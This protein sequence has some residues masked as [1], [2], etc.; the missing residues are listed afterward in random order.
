MKRI[1][2]RCAILLP[3]LALFYFSL[4]TIYKQL[5][6]GAVP[7]ADAPIP[8]TKIPPQSEPAPE[9]SAGVHPQRYDGRCRAR[10]YTPAPKAKLEIYKWVDAN[11]RTHFGDS[12]Q[13]KTAKRVD[14]K[15]D[16]ASKFALQVKERGSA[17][18]LDFR[19]QLEVRIRKSYDVLAQLLPA[20]NIRAS[21]VDLWV[22][23]SN[24]TYESFKQK[25]APGLSGAS[26]G[27]HSSRENIAAVWHKDEKQLMRT[28]IHEAAHVNN[29]AMLGVTPT[30]LNEG[31]AEYLE[32]MKVYGQTAEVEPNKGWLRTLKKQAL[33]LPMVLRS[34]RK[35]WKGKKRSALYAHSWAF[36]YFLLGEADTRALLK[37][38]LVAVAAQPCVANDFIQY[39]EANYVGG[40]AQ[41]NRK[42]SSWRPEK[43]TA[44]MY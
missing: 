38:Y 27:F 17:L 5:G 15:Q 4:P 23:S 35:D 13:S 11:G 18:P 30:W 8:T 12:R 36:V 29:W 32:R 44:H 6:I 39:S 24:A 25:Y 19:D 43:A 16:V 21:K 42:Y 31:L 10:E 33:P 9:L 3:L 1:A 26:T 20:E 40:F 7:T 41:L 22:F 2:I 37:S 34:V 28:A 14:V